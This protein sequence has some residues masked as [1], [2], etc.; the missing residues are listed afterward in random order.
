MG[1]RQVAPGRRGGHQPGHDAPRVLG[2]LDQVQHPEQH[3]RHRLAEVQDGRRPVQDQPGI[4]Q[5]GLYVVGRALRGAPQQ[6]LRVQQD[7]RV[8]VD[9]DHPGIRGFPL[10]H[11]VRVV[12][13]GDPGAD[14]QEL[15][16]A[17]LGGQVPGRPA[18]EG[19]VGAHPEPQARR[20][21]QHALGGL[22]VGGEVVLAAEPV[23]VDP[24]RVRHAGV[25]ASDAFCL[26]ARPA[27]CLGHDTPLLRSVRLAP[28]PRGSRPRRS[29]HMPPRL[30]PSLSTGARSIA[31]AGVSRVPPGPPSC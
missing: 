18:E 3:D 10:G 1:D 9:V 6:G 26:G 8:V 19:A 5:V 11:L 13:G 7:D 2:I 17:G 20:R 4:A 15:A 25:Q 23:V 22:P 30:R 14:V 24:G 31:A 16:D 27:L 21:G 29:H 28:P 12:A